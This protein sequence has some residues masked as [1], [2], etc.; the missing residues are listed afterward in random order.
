MAR[1]ARRVLD[2]GSGGVFGT[3]G[4]GPGGSDTT[5]VCAYDREAM[6]WERDGPDPETRAD[7][8]RTAH[9][10]SRVASRPYV[11]VG[12]PSAGCTC[13]VRRRY[14][15]DW[16][17]GCPGVLYDTDQLASDRKQGIATNQKQS[18]AWSRG[19]LGDPCRWR[20]GYRCC[21]SSIGV[22]EL[23]PQQRGRR[24]THPSTRHGL[25]AQ[26]SSGPTKGSDWGVR[27]PC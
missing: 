3:M 4:Q 2:A 8:R 15:D 1:A 16:G 9:L 26:E 22:T 17:G 19:A 25:P 18:F 11:M 27:E 21:P 10:L 13:N 20:S 14:P 5:R 7:H 12:H 6:G 24:C 23:P